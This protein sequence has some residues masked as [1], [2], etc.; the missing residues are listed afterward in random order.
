ML[1]A[2]SCMCLWAHPNCWSYCAAAKGAW[3]WRRFSSP[4]IKPPVAPLRSLF[5]CFISSDRYN[6]WSGW[7]SCWLRVIGGFRTCLSDLPQSFSVML[8]AEPYFIDT[9]L[10]L[11][12]HVNLCHW[13]PASSEA[14]VLEQISCSAFPNGQPFPMSSC[15]GI[16]QISVSLLIAFCW[17]LNQ[18]LLEFY[19]Q[20]TVT[21]PAFTA[22][23]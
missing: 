11:E 17:L 18:S 5:Q 19:L 21:S 10:A 9:M 4:T 12:S 8:R 16:I 23:P 13:Y 14:T 22:E 2:F 3:S 7:Y 1:L 6:H 20:S 15:P